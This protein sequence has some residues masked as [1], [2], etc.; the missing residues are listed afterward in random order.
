MN[1]NKSKLKTFLIYKMLEDNSDEDNPIPSAKIIEMLSE[2]GMECERKTI[3]SDINALNSIGCDI[4]RS[5]GVG[6]GFFI[7]SRKFQ[8]PEVML[9]IDAVTS[10]G[11]IT[12]KKTDALVNKL[13]SLVSSKQA[14]SMISQVYVDT[15]KSKCDNEEV[16]III[17]RLHGA[18]KKRKKVRFIYTRRSIDVHNKKKNTERVF[19][20]SPYALIW[21]D[22]Y[23]YL[24][25][26]KKKY[27]NLMNLRIDRMKH[28]EVTGE[29]ARPVG[30]VSPY[31]YEFDVQDYSSKMFNMFS[32]DEC[33][34]KLKC[35]LRLQEE[36]LDRFGPSIPLS[37]SDG[38]HFETVVQ[39]TLSDGLVSWLM[40]YG[41]N[42]EVLSPPELIDM[43]KIKA[44]KILNKYN[45]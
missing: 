24:V 25:C 31:K 19:T 28:L 21:K 17:D 39:A 44:N 26:N 36:M 3:Y 13:K 35:N 37:A 5:K 14:E 33:E 8:L 6:G 29:D 23:Y 10:A 18:I 38:S 7:A 11:F 42:V 27:D 4:V 43:I 41:D 32:G 34:I 9:L 20:V 16:Y 45:K 22:D 40:Q 12:P 1:S 15:N 30:D 2:Y